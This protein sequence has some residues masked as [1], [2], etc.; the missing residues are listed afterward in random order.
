M[1]GYVLQLYDDATVTQKS[2]PECRWIAVIIIVINKHCLVHEKKLTRQESKMLPPVT[3]NAF[4][5]SVFHCFLVYF[6][7]LLQ[8]FLGP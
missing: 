2:A 4:G 3:S 5:S 6:Q 1:K 7:T 8:S